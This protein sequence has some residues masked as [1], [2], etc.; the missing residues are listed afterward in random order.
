MMFEAAKV[1]DPRA[2]IAEM[3]RPDMAGMETA[4][5]A[6]ADVEA[7]A[8]TEVETA[9]T[10]TEMESAMAATAMATTTTVPPAM[11][12]TVT[13]TMSAAAGLRRQRCCDRHRGCQQHRA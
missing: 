5:M 4:K 10:A 2:M 13:A 8:T 1:R 7:V 6:A 3:R 9:V 11:A 12:A